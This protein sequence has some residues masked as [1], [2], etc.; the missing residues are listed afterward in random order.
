MDIID[1]TS[2]H[3]QL[4]YNDISLKR[5]SICNRSVARNSFSNTR[6][7]FNTIIRYSF[8]TGNAVRNI[9]TQYNEYESKK[10]IK[11]IISLGNKSILKRFSVTRIPLT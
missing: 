5:F 8:Y 11:I 1:R 2:I 6:R 4:M 9:S 3:A 7:Y 10:K